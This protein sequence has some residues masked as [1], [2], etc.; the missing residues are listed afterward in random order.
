MDRLRQNDIIHTFHDLL[1]SRNTIFLR[2]IHTND[3]SKGSLVFIVYN[4]PMYDYTKI[5]LSSLPLN[6]CVVSMFSLSL[7]NVAI[8]SL[9]NK[10]MHEYSVG[11]NQKEWNCWYAPVFNFTVDWYCQLPLHN[12]K[13]FFKIYIPTSL[14][15]RETVAT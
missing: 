2:L 9:F 14:C 5:C 4:R 7:N 8:H 11:Y 15:M 1:L 6:I 3:Y 13:M 12:A 10:Y